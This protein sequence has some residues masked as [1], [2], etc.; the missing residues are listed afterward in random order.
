M[1]RP[2]DEPTDVVLVL[3]LVLVVWV[4]VIRF[5]KYEGFFISHRSSLNVAYTLKTTFSTI[6]PYRNFNLRPN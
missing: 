3:V 5:S 2:R 1:N 4:V 6:A